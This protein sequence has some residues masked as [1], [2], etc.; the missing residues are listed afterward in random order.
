MFG[1]CCLQATIVAAEQ[2]FCRK[3]KGP[4][5]RRTGPSPGCDGGG[6]ATGRRR[7]STAVAVPLR[8]HCIKSGGHI[9]IAVADG[10]MVMD[11]ALMRLGRGGELHR[12]QDNQCRTRDRQNRLLHSSSPLNSRG[13]RPSASRSP[14]CLREIWTDDDDYYWVGNHEAASKFFVQKI[15]R[16]DIHHGVLLSDFK[17]RYQVNQISCRRSPRRNSDLTMRHPRNIHLE[18]WTRRPRSALTSS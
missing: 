12:G 18:G 14:L 7:I 10:G 6:S 4:D 16:L 5:A 15:F 8:L 17:R 3:S 9:G 1:N 2:P 13:A 11:P